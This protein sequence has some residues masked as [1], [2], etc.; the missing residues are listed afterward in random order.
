MY[1][2][3]NIRHTPVDFGQHQNL[4]LRVLYSY[5]AVI[6]GF[7]AKLIA[8]EA[9]KLSA[10]P[11]IVSVYED[12][13]RFQLLTT[14]SPGFLGLDFS[15]GIW[16][17]T[18]YG[19]DI[20]IGFIDSGIWPE[21]ASFSDD[22]LGPIPPHWKGEC[23]EGEQF[24]RS[25]CIKKLIGVR[26]FPRGM[27]AIHGPLDIAIGELDY[28]SLGDSVDH[29]TH[30][31]STATGTEVSHASLFGFANG[32]A[33]G[34]ATKARIAMYKVSWLIGNE[35]KSTS[36][37]ILAVIDKAIQDGVHCLSLSIGSLY[38]SYH[39]NFISLGAFTAMRKGIFVSAAVG[40]SGLTFSVDNTTPWMTTVAVGTID[41]TFMGKFM[42]GKS[43]VLLGTSFVYDL[44]VSSNRS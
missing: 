16:P 24:N 10:V 42:L 31:A 25:C 32:T 4:R 37:D 9:A 5:E 14:R 33:R 17:E 19:E 28:S 8:E 20:V 34:V 18:G 39:K 38:Q 3:V 41:R 26:M 44:K 2:Y 15:N 1:T 36:S 43:E 21:S 23:E 40:N 6:S 12:T 35:Q 13:D 27:E 11:G 22:G 29:E 7:A 30:V